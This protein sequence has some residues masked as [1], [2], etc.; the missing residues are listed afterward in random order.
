MF[1]VTW[2]MWDNALLDA[3][4]PDA[5]RS[6]NK[7]YAYPHLVISS[8]HDIMHMIEERYGDRLPV[9]RGDFSEY[10]TDGLGTAARQTRMCLNARE[11]LVQAETV[12]PMLRP[13]KPAPRDDFEEAWRNIVMCTEH[14]FATENPGEPYFQDAIWRGK[15]RYFREAEDRSQSLLDDALAPATVC[16]MTKSTR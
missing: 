12:W 13:G 14:T 6:W 11:R 16:L 15:Q 1:V 7:E 8:A 4:L 10:W 2:A 3:D 5:V 9:V